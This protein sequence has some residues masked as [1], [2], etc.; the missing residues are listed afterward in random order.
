MKIS[1]QIIA[2]FGSALLFFAPLAQA[3]QLRDGN[4]GLNMIASAMS[5]TATNLDFGDVALSAVPENREVTILCLSGVPSP[6][7]EADTRRCGEVTVTS[8]LSNFSYRLDAE[9]T[10]L[11]DVD[12]SS[13][14]ATISPDLGLYTYG[15]G[16]PA[17]GLDSFTPSAPGSTTNIRVDSANPSPHRYEVAGVLTISPNRPGRYEGTYTIT[18]VVVE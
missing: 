11:S 16:G 15:T 18:A 2:V 7:R 8:T 3:Q 17:F 10:L 12:R 13:N 14:T 4:V 5:V 1:K 6:R 9:V